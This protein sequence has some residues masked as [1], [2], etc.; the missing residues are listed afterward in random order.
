LK[1]LVESTSINPEFDVLLK[2]FCAILTSETQSLLSFS[3][4]HGD[5]AFS[6]GRRCFYRDSSIGIEAFTGT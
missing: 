3:E 1:V 5:K 4:R 6:C 2:R